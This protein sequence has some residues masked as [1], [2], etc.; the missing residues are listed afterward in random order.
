MNDSTTGSKTSRKKYEKPVLLSFPLVADEV[1][2]SAC[3]VTASG[4]GPV[5]QCAT[6]IVCSSPT[7][8]GS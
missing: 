7:N 1:M 6:G 2:S 8:L 5:G 4:T 3:K